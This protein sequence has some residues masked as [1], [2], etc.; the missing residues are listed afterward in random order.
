[1]T[2]LT[3]LQTIKRCFVNSELIK[4]GLSR[5][6]ST[7]RQLSLSGLKSLAI[8][9]VLQCTL[10][11]VPAS[12]QPQS[13]IEARMIALDSLGSL[14]M[15]FN[16]SF[17]NQDPALQT[18]YQQGF[19]MLTIWASNTGQSGNVRRHLDSINKHISAL[20]QEPDEYAHLRPVWIN[21]TVQSHAQLE[22]LLA[23]KDKESSGDVFN[24]LSLYLAMQNVAYQTATFSSINMLLMDGRLDIME[25]L[26]EKITADIN[27]MISATDAEWVRKLQTRYLFIRGRLVGHQENW[28]PNLVAY[29]YHNMLDLLTSNQTS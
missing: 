15:F 27:Q 14:L 19:Q 25:V 17:K 12:A 7:G 29:Y 24:R 23:S 2:R 8:L 26:D 6:Y 22:K 11:A 4:S 18:R 1:M 9:M 20:E 5:W 16:P 10:F 21:K 13:V 3:Q 28:V